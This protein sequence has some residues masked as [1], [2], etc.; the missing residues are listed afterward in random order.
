MPG[1]PGRRQRSRRSYEA[2]QAAAASVADNY[3]RN[4]RVSYSVLK[5]GL[6]DVNAPMVAAIK[7][8]DADADANA[9]KN[10]AGINIQEVWQIVSDVDLIADDPDPI[11]LN[12]TDGDSFLDALIEELLFIHPDPG[13]GLQLISTRDSIAAVH[14]EPLSAPITEESPEED[15]IR[16]L[17]HCRKL[18]KIAMRQ[19]PPGKFTGSD[20][21]DK[22]YYYK[23]D[24]AYY[25]NH[26]DGMLRYN[27]SLYKRRM[28][29]KKKNDKKRKANGHVPMEIVDSLTGVMRESFNRAMRK[30][31][32][33]GNIRYL[34]ESNTTR[35]AKLHSIVMMAI[36]LKKLLNSTPYRTNKELLKLLKEAAP[37]LESDKYK[38]S[39]LKKS[40]HSTGMKSEVAKE[41][42]QQQMLTFIIWAKTEL[43]AMPRAINKQKKKKEEEDARR[44][45]TSGAGEADTEGKASQPST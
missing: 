31:D 33:A 24:K 16:L 6:F 11:F 26:R 13:V 32:I 1:G 27:K 41:K 7:V 20:V 8:F 28:I 22:Y 29:T 15:F 38:P 39:E 34:A 23:E 14:K 2:N 36:V 35:A 19:L 9:D 43:L 21:D 4:F 44:K 5:D 45:I 25:F 37:Y 12:A 3:R 17:A 42:E 18:K 40:Y 30:L 10:N